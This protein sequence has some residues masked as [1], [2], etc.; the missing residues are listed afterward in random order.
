MA[1]DSLHAQGLDGKSGGSISICLFMRS[2]RK[3]GFLVVKHLYS[4]SQL[5]MLVSSETEKNLEK[6]QGLV[7]HS[8]QE[9][10]AP[11][12]CESA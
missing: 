3:P 6:L 12:C 8:N 1:A 5:E 10:V 7:A 9:S 11:N 4:S 2:L